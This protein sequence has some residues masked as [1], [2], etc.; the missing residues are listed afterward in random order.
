MGDY[1]LSED[2][3]KQAGYKSASELSAPRDLAVPL[4]ADFRETVK[5]T[6]GS[7]TGTA[8]QQQAATEAAARI[9]TAIDQAEALI[10]HALS[11]GGYETPATTAQD[12]PVLAGIARCL[13]LVSLY[14]DADPPEIVGKEKD[15]AMAYLKMIREGDVVIDGADRAIAGEIKVRSRT[16]VYTAAVLAGL[17][18]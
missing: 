7:L 3:A 16:Q 5:A 15:A 12:M 11:S 10:N 1:L 2:F 9:N 6:P 13:A 17:P 4:A 18:G 8:E 14:T